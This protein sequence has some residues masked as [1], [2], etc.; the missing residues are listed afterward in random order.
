MTDAQVLAELFR[1][2][3]TLWPI[4]PA[5]FEDLATLRYRLAASLF[6][7]P[8][9]GLS[10]SL[11]PDADATGVLT[12]LREIVDAVAQDLAAGIG[13]PR[14]RVTRRE[15][16]LLSAHQPAPFAA[17]SAGRAVTRTF[18]PMLE[19]DERVVVF[20]LFEA[21]SFLRV[22]T[23]QDGV[24]V[25]LPPDA[26]RADDSTFTFGQG[27]VWLKAG[28]LAPS[29]GWVGLGV[30]SGSV[31]FA[32][33]V[34]PVDDTILVPVGA[35][36]T[37]SLAIG[38]AA[39]PAA[40]HGPGEDA[41]RANVICPAN[42]RF[43]LTTAA[44]QR[45]EADDGALAV[46]GCDVGLVRIDRPPVIAD[47]TGGILIPFEPS[48]T[49]DLPVDVRSTL[50]QPTGTWTFSDAGWLLPVTD[51]TDAGELGA[52]A[53]AG[54]MA[55][56]IDSSFQAD[57]RGLD[58]GRFVAE[59]ALVL[60]DSH[61][62][63]VVADGRTPRIARQE[64]SLWRESSLEL[65]FVD[66]FRLQFVA[67]RE[68]AEVLALTAR[69]MAHLDRPLQADGKHPRLDFD[70][71]SVA[72]SQTTEGDRLLVT[73]RREIDP[74]LVLP[75]AL[76]NA[77]LRSTAADHLAI[78]GWISDER[79]V[80][81]GTVHLG[82]GLHAV[83][84]FLP[85]P[86]CSNFDSPPFE[87]GRRPRARLSIATKWSG[88]FFVT[89]T[90]SMMALDGA[91][92]VTLL[93]PGR[94]LVPADEDDER[95][96]E[97]LFDRTIN[98]RDLRRHPALVLVDLSTYADQLGVAAEIPILP[99]DRSPIAMDGLRLVAS[100][101]DLRVV[102]LPQV[103]W[104][105][106]RTDPADLRP[107]FPQPFVARDDGGPLVFGVDTNA[108][109]ADATVQL[110]PVAPEPLVQWLVELANRDDTAAAIRF[111]LPFG[112]RA[113]AAILPDRDPV[114]MRPRLALNRPVFEQL[115]GGV[116]V[117]LEAAGPD[118]VPG[119]AIQSRNSR[120]QPPKSVLDDEVDGFFNLAFHPSDTISRIPISRID[121]SGYGAS[122]ASRWVNENAA[123]VDVTKVEFDILVGRTST[124]V[125]EIQSIL[126]PC[127]ARVVRRITIRRDGS[128]TVVRRDSGWV[129][130]SPGL[131]HRPD[132]ACVV[133]PGAVRGMFNVRE[134]R[135]TPRRIR[136]NPG[137][138]LQAVYFDTDLGI[139]DVV[140]GQVSEGPGPHGETVRF[141]PSQGQLGFV[142]LINLDS[143][144]QTPLTPDQLAELLTRE[145][146]VGG[147][148]D[149]ELDI[150]GSGQRMRTTSLYTDV[151][152]DAQT[153]TRHFAVATYGTP[154]LPRAGQW[155]VVRL[156]NLPV[157]RPEPEPVDPRRGVPLIRLGRAA[158]PPSASTGPH[159]FA[160]P[161]DLLTLPAPT[162][163][164]ALLL[165][166]QTFRVLFPRP[167]IEL[168]AR[169]ITSDLPPLLAD[170]HSMLQATGLF[171]RLNSAIAF[172]SNA[173]ELRLLDGDG[174]RLLP[175]PLSQSVPQPRLLEVLKTTGLHVFTEYRGGDRHRQGAA[176]IELRFDS[177]ADPS[178]SLDIGPISTVTD[179]DP[180]GKVMRLITT[181]H[182]DS[183]SRPTGTNSVMEYGGALRAVED[184]IT[185]MRE[186]GIPADLLVETPNS[187]GHETTKKMKYGLHVKLPE[188]NIFGKV[189]GE[190][191]T[192][193]ELGTQKAASPM[194]P[195]ASVALYAEVEGEVEIPI[196]KPIH[197]GGFVKLEFEIGYDLAKKELVL[198]IKLAA[199]VVGSVGGNLIP[200]LLRV[201]GEIKYGYVFV[202]DIAKGEYYPGVL[203]GFSLECTIV[204]LIKLAFEAE[205][206]GL[207]KRVNEDEIHVRAEFTVAGE[208]ELF[209]LVDVEYSVETEWDVRL[210]MKAVA[211][212]G[213]AVGLGFVPVPIPP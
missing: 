82:F 146:P 162:T 31:S 177:T 127:M 97:M 198:E 85:D 188:I 16:P 100:A 212:L 96:L 43:E 124:E 113:V 179:V 169:Q 102:A 8:G 144:Q 178:W 199:G 153:D 93:P 206:I 66:T 91:D 61:E 30:A 67:S 53:G 119:G 83:M 2:T 204:H 205:V 168:G 68:Q 208:V 211:A 71:A 137:V 174:M 139:E 95:V 41:A 90:P 33:P 98:R 47:L 134:I 101:N 152:V 130:A 155:S 27:S 65:Q 36:L 11:P 170:V 17:R 145:R 148:I 52:A 7:L 182:A 12:R 201:E 115:A 210:P 125:V 56:V 5:T 136:I 21:S 185:V 158:D 110:V 73:A 9:D 39:M 64:L 18:G 103:Q 107:N 72:L 175:S 150:G 200:Y 195:Q 89:L 13:P 62:L 88:E 106:L 75:L 167:K 108:T 63:S 121:L 140:R 25:L 10:S 142:Q 166:T 116:Q 38:S 26:Q 59:R 176:T 186:F 29:Q 77:L 129:A 131:F 42:A 128:A 135:D 117:T 54:A 40:A 122:A 1:L 92:L 126:W 44:V 99:G 23:G 192:G 180:F 154:V 81:S 194:E 172:P 143:Q 111:T 112:I 60:A 19:D 14:A 123:A 34:A 132:S 118:G 37:L 69:T 191:Q 164:Y 147:P 165:A 51:V 120:S 79:R 70:G 4:E 171:P 49:E 24:L 183:A 190:L 48:R 22:A 105:P 141:V 160:D 209:S 74:D 94:E 149:C 35:S 193:L 15:L 207:V 114:T 187:P 55:L 213:L 58:G 161:S 86:Y 181:L 202:A 196:I 104:E 156:R 203:L 78:R 45:I 84:P 57:W 189:E 80:T 50:L 173:Y 163:D 109:D 28:V 6:D 159:R 157:D 197:G 46:Y 138:D 184:L 3:A 133:H 87:A 32:D 20:D 76:S 151:A